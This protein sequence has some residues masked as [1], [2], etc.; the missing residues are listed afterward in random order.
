VT[1]VLRYRKIN[2]EGKNWLNSGNAYNYSNTSAFPSHAKQCAML[3]LLCC[4]A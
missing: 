3:E 2:K 1:K 4:F